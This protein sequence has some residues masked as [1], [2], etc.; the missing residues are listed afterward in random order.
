MSLVVYKVVRLFD[1]L[2]MRTMYK[3]QG[4]YLCQ[5]FAVYSIFLSIYSLLMYSSTV[6]SA[7]V[8]C[9]HAS[10][11]TAGTLNRRI[12]IPPGLRIRAFRSTGKRLGSVWH[13]GV[14]HGPLKEWWDSG[15]FN[16]NVGAKTGLIYIMGWVGYRDLDIKVQFSMEVLAK[17]FKERRSAWL[18]SPDGPEEISKLVYSRNK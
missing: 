14:F 12:V 4:I 16:F 2:K 5:M 15:F 6:S 11:Q 7:D 13:L 8:S 1:H 17:L 9:I 3:G 18:E 10:M